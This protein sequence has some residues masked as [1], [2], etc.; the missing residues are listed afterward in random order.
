MQKYGNDYAKLQAKLQ[1]KVQKVCF[2]SIHERLST[3]RLNP[4][5]LCEMS[6]IGF[7]VWLDILRKCGS[8]R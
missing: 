8:S 4:M 7:F 1:H 2:M 6:F 3:Y 5:K